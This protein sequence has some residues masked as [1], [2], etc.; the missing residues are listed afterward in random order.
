MTPASQNQISNC[1]IANDRKIVTFAKSISV[2]SQKYDRFSEAS[3]QLSDNELN[4]ILSDHN[5]Q[6]DAIISV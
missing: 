4:Q 6:S 3:L 1:G 5:Q 2:V